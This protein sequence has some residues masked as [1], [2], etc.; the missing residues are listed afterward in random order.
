MLGRCAREVGRPAEA[1]VFFKRELEIREAKLEPGDLSVANTLYELGSCAR[2]ASR[3]RN[4]EAFLM[5]AVNILLL[6]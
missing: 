1:E 2:R 3:W 6:E 4:E 5:W